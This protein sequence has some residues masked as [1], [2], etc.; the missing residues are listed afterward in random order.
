MQTSIDKNHL[1]ADYRCKGFRDAFH[2]KSKYN[3]FVLSSATQEKD[4]Q[5]LASYLQKH[6][7]VDTIFTVDLD[8]FD[9][10]YKL[11]IGKFKSQIRVFIASDANKNILNAIKDGKVMLTVSQQ[12]Y[13]QGF[14]PVLFFAQLKTSGL[15]P[16]DFVATGPL[17]ININ[18]VN[19][20]IKDRRA[21]GLLM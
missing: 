21:L 3:R 6:T 16:L 20:Y 10:A 7:D 4:R 12:E 19:K 2:D 17:L 15:S 9:A 8:S 11:A 18:N 5:T 14:L 13:L 1:G